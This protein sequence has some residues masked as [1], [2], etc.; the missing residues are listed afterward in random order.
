MLRPNSKALVSVWLIFRSSPDCSRS[1]ARLA[2]PSSRLRPLL[3]NVARITSGL[4]AGKFDG[5][6]ALDSCL[7]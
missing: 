5:E 4:V 2:T 6:S 1:C 7:R 3:A